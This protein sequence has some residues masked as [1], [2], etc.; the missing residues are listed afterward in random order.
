L[1]SE[2]SEIR[3]IA[4]NFVSVGNDPE[5]LS[6]MWRANRGSRYAMPL[7][8]VPEGGQVSENS[9]H[10]STK[11]LC[12]V[13]HENVVGSN[14]ANEARVFSPKTGSLPVKTARR[15][16]P[17]EILAREPTADDIDG[18]SVSAKS[19][20]CKGSDI[21]VPFDV[22]PVLREDAPAKW[23][24]LALRHGFEP[25]RSFQAKLESA[26]SRKQRENL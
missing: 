22:R 21:L 5:A 24:N 13:F 23:I 17:R 1:E 26:Y 20:G 8:I 19:V 9:V 4:A 15:A 14:L 10:P 6:G 16:S 25:A 3:P 7:R 12:D 2:R 11:Q 18:N